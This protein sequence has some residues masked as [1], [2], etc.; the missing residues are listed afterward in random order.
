MVARVH[1]PLLLHRG[2]EQFSQAH[3][4]AG[5]DRFLQPFMV[6]SQEQGQEQGNGQEQREVVRQGVELPPSLHLLTLRRTL[7]EEQGVFLLIRLEHIYQV[8]TGQDRT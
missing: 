8:R 2:E 6:F 4:E 3:R 1:H 7:Q 5:V